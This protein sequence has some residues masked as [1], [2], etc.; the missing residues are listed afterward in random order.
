MLSGQVQLRI[1]SR[2]VSS[3][4]LLKQID[5]LANE[6]RQRQSRHSPLPDRPAVLVALTE[7]FTSRK[8]PLGEEIA[9]YEDMALRLI[10]DSDAASL[11]HVAARLARHPQQQF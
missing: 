8:Q 2:F 10:A 4:E 5:G 6:V 7:L 1:M 11:A 9:R 3:S